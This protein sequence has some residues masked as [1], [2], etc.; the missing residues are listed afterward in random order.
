M[1]ITTLTA[2]KTIKL[3]RYTGFVLIEYLGYTL[4]DLVVRTKS[5]GT[6]FGKSPQIEKLEKAWELVRNDKNTGFWL[7]PD[8]LK[9]YKEHAYGEYPEQSDKIKEGCTSDAIQALD[10]K[11]FSGVVFGHE[12]DGLVYDLDSAPVNRV[13]T[14]EAIG[15]IFN[16]CKALATKLAKYPEV[17][18]AEYYDAHC[19]ECGDGVRF[20]AKLTQARLESLIGERGWL[21]HDCY[22]KPVRTL[23]PCL[24]EHYSTD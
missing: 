16:N 21:S 19:S 2:T 1:S 7:S 10:S 22:E 8:E 4:R 6:I 14:F 24:D 9:W 5:F 13:L 23:F 3:H 20:Q 11:D 15:S 17:I 12:H 18:K